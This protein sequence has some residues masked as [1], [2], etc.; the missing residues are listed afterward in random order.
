MRKKRWLKFNVS[1]LLTFVLVAL[2]FISAHGAEP[3]PAA[4]QKPYNIEIYSL[5]QGS[6]VYV[7]G[8]ALADLINKHSPWLRATAI[9]SRGNTANTRL[10][11][12]DL[13]KRKNT[14]AN[15]NFTD[16]FFAKEG[17]LPGMEGV[18]YETS[19]VVGLICLIGLGPVTLDP[20]IKNIKD[21]AGKRFA[22]G[23]KAV[24]GQSEKVKG[25]FKG[26]GVYDKIKFE[27]MEFEKA[28]DALL[29]GLIDGA[30]FGAIYIG[31]GKW[32]PS[33]ALEELL[34]SK[35]VHFVQWNPEDISEAA[36]LLQVPQDLTMNHVV[37]QPGRVSPK[38]REP[39]SV[40]N[41]YML[42]GADVDMPDEVAHEICR[43]MYEHS[44]EFG[45][46]HITGKAI[47]KETLSKSESTDPKW[48]H[49]GAL[50]F[51]KEKGLQL[52]PIKD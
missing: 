45:K 50:K 18:K 28:K 35:D 17:R 46:Y 23:P 1:F 4:V 10:L 21:F 36:R 3:T 2:P 39:W 5:F 52:G 43:I 11:A 33:P 32:A 6:S 22:V 24:W 44:A 42:W 31:G 40:N 38:Q 47:T 20:K 30:S 29:D 48:V 34:V 14:I 27:N 26:A 12:T 37:I 41:T 51:F 9:A 49:P 7:L 15:I 13:K 19:K 16:H 8:V 25:I